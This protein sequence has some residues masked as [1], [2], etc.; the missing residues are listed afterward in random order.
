VPTAR[1]RD[2][3]RILPRWAWGLLAY[4]HGAGPRPKLAPK[5]PPAWYWQWAAW[6][7]APFHLKDV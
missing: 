3:P 7:L 2:L 1:P 6:R 4:Q 5:K